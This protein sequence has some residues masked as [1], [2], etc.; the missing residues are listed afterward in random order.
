MYLK[1]KGYIEAK[2]KKLTEQLDVYSNYFD[3]SMQ[4]WPQTFSFDEVKINK[5]YN[6]AV[7]AFEEKEKIYIGFRVNQDTDSLFD[8]SAPISQFVSKINGGWKPSPADPSVINLFVYLVDRE[9]FFVPEKS[10]SSPLP[11]NSLVR[12]TSKTSDALDDNAYDENL[13]NDLLS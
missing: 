13:T 11:E 7:L 3:F 4:L 5:S 1:W 8:L 2:I 6:S 12:R 10:F 9:S